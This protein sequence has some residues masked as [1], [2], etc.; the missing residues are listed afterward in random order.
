MM[1]FRKLHRLGREVVSG[2]LDALLHDELVVEPWP[3]LG[4]SLDV[5]LRSALS[6]VYA[7]LRGY[8][9]QGPDTTPWA[10]SYRGEALQEVEA[11][12]VVGPS[13]EDGE[14]GQK[15]Y[16]SLF[17]NPWDTWRLPLPE[18]G[19]DRR[20]SALEV[21]HGFNCL[22][23]SSLQTSSF[24]GHLGGREGQVVVQ[25]VVNLQ[26]RE[27]LGYLKCPRELGIIRKPEAH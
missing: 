18:V 20:P 12:V 2:I 23:A 25:G 5:V 8:L 11:E 1:E 27:H 22:K 15:A 13:H 9:P 24:R 7:V 21:T 26:W 10:V 19:S 4:V 16:V 17:G 3:G 6:P 14:E